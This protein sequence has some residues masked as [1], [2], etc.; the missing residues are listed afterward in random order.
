MTI[1]ERGE[2][3]DRFQTS[4]ATRNWGVLRAL[5]TEGADWRV[6]GDRSNSVETARSSRS[7]EPKI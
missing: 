4:L 2:L 1:E 7:Q 5:L 3:A 6:P